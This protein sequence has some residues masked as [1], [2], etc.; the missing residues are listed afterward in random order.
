MMKVSAAKHKKDDDATWEG[1]LERIE[2]AALRM[3]SEKVSDLV[4]KGA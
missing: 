2:T 4:V 1:D 3:E